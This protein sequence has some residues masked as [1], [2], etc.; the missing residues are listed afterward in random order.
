MTTLTRHTKQFVQYLR[1]V[2]AVSALEYAILIGVVATAI[3]VVLNQLGDS[4]EET[5]KQAK[6]KVE[7]AQRDSGLRGN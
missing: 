7:R 6:S 4:V 2:K 3:A 5:I 1:T